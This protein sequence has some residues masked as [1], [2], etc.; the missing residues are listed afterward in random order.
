MPECTV[1]LLWKIKD[2]SS[3]EEH[4]PRLIH[5]SATEVPANSECSINKQTNKK[6]KDIS[7]TGELLSPHDNGDNSFSLSTL[8]QRWIGKTPTP[9]A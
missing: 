9:E 5:H 7:E 6:M 3:Q 2:R 8:S 4:G 1:L